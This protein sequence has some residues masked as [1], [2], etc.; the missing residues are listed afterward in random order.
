[1]PLGFAKSILTTAAAAPATPSAA[2]QGF[3]GSEFKAN[4]TEG[5]AH[6]VVDLGSGNDWHASHD[7][8]YQIMFWM[9][10]TT[11]DFHSNGT[12][13]VLRTNSDNSGD[14]GM[15][16][17]FTSTYVQAGTQVGSGGGSFHF[18]KWSPTGF[19]T[20]YLDN[21]WHHFLFEVDGTSSKL[22]VDGV[23][24]T[25]EAV[26]NNIGGSA[27]GDIG[28]STR[29][30]FIAGS[31]TSRGDGSYNG[32]RT[33][34]FEFADVWFKNKSTGN[35]ASN[36]GS[37]YN[38]G[39]VDLG[40]DGTLGSTLPAPDIFLY[41]RADGSSLGSALVSGASVSTVKATNGVFIE[42]AINGPGTLEDVSTAYRQTNALSTGN[43]AG[44]TIED[45]TFKA[46]NDVSMVMWFRANGADNDGDSDDWIDGT[47]G[48]SSGSCFIQIP[49]PSGTGS[50]N[51]GFL[52]LHFT[53]QDFGWQFSLN[54]S[55]TDGRNAYIDGRGKGTPAV[56][57][58]HSFDGGWNCL[59]IS[60]M[61]DHDTGGT[62]DTSGTSDER[63]HQAVYVGDED[64][65]NMPAGHTRGIWKGATSGYSDGH[66]GYKHTA[67]T[68]TYQE[69]SSNDKGNIGPG[70]HIGPVWV[71]N[72]YL[73]FNTE[74]V[75]RR[76]FNSSNT[77]GYVTPKTNGTTSAGATQPQLFL[78]HNGTDLVNGG[79]DKVTLTERKV[80][81]GSF[82]AIGSSQGPGSG[83]TI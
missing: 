74:S 38:S 40:T 11:S 12:Q 29:Y 68:T 23:N 59:M 16:C 18:F 66:I 4:D 58:A 15:F 42:S 78:F 79:S 71:Y 44:L 37:I 30:A 61:S 49:H 54:S 52:R 53:L 51:G 82:T 56:Q 3:F 80:G 67:F 77:D 9:K 34:T 36:A 26:D 76:F 10:G 32:F 70:I 6:P 57:A 48:G 27:Q 62:S 63:D 73:N 13:V 19:A 75:R 25:S 39:W 69:S 64:Y 47:S 50:P 14:N 2:R 35:L 46:D 8:T 43:L 65:T 17:E 24:K 41:H 20:N 28:G 45:V 22:Y 7:G 33:G 60:L 83:T 31:T 5:A 55:E 81:T 21:N 1:M 72:E